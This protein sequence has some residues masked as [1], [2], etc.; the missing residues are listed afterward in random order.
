MAEHEASH[1][2]LFVNAPVSFSSV[3]ASPC[4]SMTPPRILQATNISEDTI[5]N[6]CA[7]AEPNE[8][9]GLAGAY[10]PGR[11][12]QWLALCHNSDQLVLQVPSFSA[13]VGGEPLISPALCF[14]RAFSHIPK[15]CKFIAFDADTL[16]VGLYLQ[17]GARLSPCIHV[18][19]VVMKKGKSLDSLDV[20]L[21]LNPPKILGQGRYNMARHH[22]MFDDRSKSDTRV[23]GLSFRSWA[24]NRLQYTYGKEI[25]GTP[26]IN[27]YKLSDEVRLARDILT[28]ARCRTQH[29]LSYKVMRVVAKI[30][31]DSDRI[32]SVKPQVQ[33]HDIECIKG[34]G[35]G[36]GFE[37]IGSRYNTRTRMTTSNQVCS[38]VLWSH[39]SRFAMG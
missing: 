34:G 28:M 38:S 18:Q 9:I 3:L 30:V 10:G 25:K 35:G 31:Q 33:K 14:Q 27:A 39:I 8:Y 7:A 2:Y 37:A 15:T 36:R 32:D 16:T 12:L 11:K 26:M 5:S 21:K 19:S 23:E 13:F 1:L 24:A 22:K 20:I 4:L 29:L 17:C 6:F